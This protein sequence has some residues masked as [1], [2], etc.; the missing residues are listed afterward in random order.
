[1]ILSL[2]IALITSPVIAVIVSAKY[3]RIKTVPLLTFSK[4]NLATCY[5]IEG[6]ALELYNKKAL[7]TLTYDLYD[8]GFNM[9]DNMSFVQF[10]QNVMLLKK[11][12]VELDL[13]KESDL[14]NNL[15]KLFELAMDIKTLGYLPIV[16]NILIATIMILVRNIGLVEAQKTSE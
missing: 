12:I 10:T 15:N 6:S 4:K 7:Q 11:D 2:L 1:M 16:L 5:M 9:H 3:N 8:I 14:N 13:R